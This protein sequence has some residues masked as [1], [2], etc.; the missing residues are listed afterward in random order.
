[1]NVLIIKNIVT[2]GPGTIGDYLRANNYPYSIIDLQR[3]TPLPDIAAFT[4]LVIMGGPMA[5]YEMDLHPFLVEEAKFIETAIKAK[6]RILG[7]CLGA[8]MLARVFG[9]RVY[10]GKEKEIGWYDVSLTSDGIA[11]P[12]M[13][14]LKIPG[15]EVAEVF[16]W[17]G[18]T[19]DL[20]QGATLLASSPICTNQ[21][22]KYT[23]H[24]YAL[25][26]HIEVTPE[27]VHDWLRNEKA[28]DVAAIDVKSEQIFNTYGKRAMAF[29]Q[30]FF[31]A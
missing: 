2:E 26:F 1:M 24:V 23:E 12:L 31:Q 19:F 13:S 25:Q 7:I 15:K 10:P 8:Q 5:V 6:K 27:I 16:Q 3:G 14:Q 4:H 28:V 11:D 9:A 18:D 17:H 22:F 21:A 29:Y 20:P 30:K